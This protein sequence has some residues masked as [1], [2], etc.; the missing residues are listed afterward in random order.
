MIGLLRIF[1]HHILGK[2]RNSS[3]DSLAL[4][5]NADSSTRSWYSLLPRAKREMIT[6][7]GVLDEYIYR[8]TMM[9]P[10]YTVDTHRVLSNLA[11]DPIERI[12]TCSPAPPPACLPA[13]Y[14]QEAPSHTAKILQAANSL[15]ELLTLPTRISVHTPFSICMVSSVTI[16]HLSA[17]KNVFQGEQLQIARDRIRVA[18]GTLKAFGEVWPRGK[19]T[20]SEVQIIARELLGISL[21]SD[22]TATPPA[23]EPGWSASAGFQTASLDFSALDTGA[24]FDTLLFS[25]SASFD[26]VPEFSVSESGSYQGLRTAESSLS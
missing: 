12:S 10:V 14:R 25:N 16:A 21:N 17:C 22:K 19:R 18:M 23:I 6:S 4:C 11:F 1:D 9:I 13:L 5:L 7:D 3:A 24:L 15:T 20:H 26:M 8:A 2:Q